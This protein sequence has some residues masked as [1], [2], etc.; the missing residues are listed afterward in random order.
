MKT[1]LTEDWVQIPK[2]VTVT[3]K[4][5]VVAVTGPRGC[6]TKDF[7][8]LPCEIQRTKKAGPKSEEGTYLRIRMWFGGARHAC[9]VKTLKSL[10]NNMIVGVTEVSPPLQF[11]QV[12]GPSRFVAYGASPLLD[13]VFQLNLI[14]N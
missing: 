8:H 12:C 14:N 7:S 9:A 5:R 6:V 1:L 10:I 4:A 3:V 11:T 2:D 13:R